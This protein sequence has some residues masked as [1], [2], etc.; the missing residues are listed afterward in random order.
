MKRILIN[1]H[2]SEIKIFKDK[3]LLVE[4]NINDINNGL[5]QINQIIKNYNDLRNEIEILN[6]KIKENNDK[7]INLNDKIINRINQM[8]NIN[9]IKF[10]EQENINDEIKNIIY[11]NKINYEFIKDPKNLKFKSDI[12]TTNTSA[13]WND[14]FEIFISYKD[15]KEYL[16]FSNSIIFYLDIFLL[17]NNQKIES[18]KGHK[19]DIMIIRYFIN[20]TN[21]N[22]YLISGD[23]DKLVIIWDIN[24]NFNIKH[25]IETNYGYLILSCLLRYIINII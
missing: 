9:N 6:N 10:K 25:K 20:N 7:N 17:I 8:E 2:E 5:K 16:V 19:N 4:N 24:D 13:G 18:L 11:K 14:I 23:D 12:T 22:E 21:K 3:I 1:K 15:N